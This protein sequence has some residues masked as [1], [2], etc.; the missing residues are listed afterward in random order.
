MEQKR[1]ATDVLLSIEEKIDIIYNFMQN[2]DNTTKLILNRLNNLEKKSVPLEKAVA[3]FGD[4]VPS[5]SAP[6]EDISPKKQKTQTKKNPQKINMP[7]NLEENVLRGL[8][9]NKRIISVSQKILH[10]DGTEATFADVE[11][12]NSEGNSITTTKTNTSGRW[13]KT[14]NPGNYK[15]HIAKKGNGKNYNDLNLNFTFT[16]SDSEK[17]IELPTPLYSKK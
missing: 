10:P 4:T 15:A 17:P 12:F 8:D 14:L 1:T 16:V 7:K 11:I 9:D 3:S 6:I 5:V 2:L 13:I